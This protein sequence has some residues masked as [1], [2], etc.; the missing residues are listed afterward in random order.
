M[1][2]TSPPSPMR[3]A[4]IASVLLL[5][6]AL[7]ACVAGSGES[8]H[9]ASG[10]ALAQFLLGLWQGVIGPL[11]L[12][13]EIINRLLPHLLPWHVRFYETTAAGPFYDVGFFLGLV[14]GPLAVRSRF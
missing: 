14:G 4:N 9:A 8:Q 5:M 3:P 2:A 6:F 13:A 11:T 1:S 12:L 7:T 10:G